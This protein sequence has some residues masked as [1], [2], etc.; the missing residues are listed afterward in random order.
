MR[1]RITAAA[2]RGDRIHMRE[3]AR[4]TAEV[5]GDGK[6]ALAMAKDNWD[7]QK[8]LADARLLAECAAAAHD[9]DGADAVRTWARDTGVKDAQLDRWL[10]GAR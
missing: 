3:Q 8:E 1:D 9:P 7:V 6:A 5:D 2:E 4:F 10:G